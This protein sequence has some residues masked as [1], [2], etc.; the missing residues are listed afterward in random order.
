[1]RKKNSDYED[2]KR[3]ISLDVHNMYK[4]DI[5]KYHVKVELDECK[6]FYIVTVF[7]HHVASVY[8]HTNDRDHKIREAIHIAVDSAIAVEHELKARIEGETCC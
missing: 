6:C 8:R 4:R 3:G 5:K 7:S 2:V 1:M